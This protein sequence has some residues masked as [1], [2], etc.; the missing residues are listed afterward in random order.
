MY[1]RYGGGHTRPRTLEADDIAGICDIFPPTESVNTE[2]CEPRHGF[3]RECDGGATL[4]GHGGCVI[5]RTRRGDASALSVAALFGL[6]LV[7][8]RLRRG[9]LSA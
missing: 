3:S 5:S 1:R 9:R 6:G 8:R 7:V 4:G 2:L